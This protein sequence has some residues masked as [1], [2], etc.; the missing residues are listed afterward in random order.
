MLNILFRRTLL[1]VTFVG[2]HSTSQKM[3]KDTDLKSPD[4]S[5]VPNPADKYDIIFHFIV[6]T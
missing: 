5:N 2:M 4:V 1:S 6:G 3:M